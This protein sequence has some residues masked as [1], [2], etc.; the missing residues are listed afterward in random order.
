MKR[1]TVRTSKPSRTK[2][3]GKPP[4][5]L[6]A[7]IS[8]RCSADLDM[9]VTTSAQALGISLDLAW[10]EAIAFNLRLILHDAKLVDEF[11]LPDC[12]EPAPVFYA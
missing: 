11:Q 2:R 4:S 1:K 12:I 7:R 9:L 8:S 6:S 3:A 10:R 5:R